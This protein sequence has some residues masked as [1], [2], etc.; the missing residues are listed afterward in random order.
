[1][2]QFLLKV[3]VVLLAA[4]PIFANTAVASYATDKKVAATDSTEEI[5]KRLAEIEAQLAEC[6]NMLSYGMVM[7]DYNY[8]K[9]YDEV[10]YVDDEKLFWHNSEGFDNL[11]AEMDLIAVMLNDS[12]D[13]CQYISE[14]IVRVRDSADYTYEE[15][16]EFCSDIEVMVMEVMT[17][18][19]EINTRLD[20]FEAVYVDFICYGVNQPDPATQYALYHVPTGKYLTYS[21]GVIELSDTQSPFNMEFVMCDVNSSYVTLI[22]ADG[23]V[24]QSGG[25]TQ[26][27]FTPADTVN[28]MSDIVVPSGSI[29]DMWQ[30][31]VYDSTPT[32]ISSATTGVPDSRRND[33]YYNLNGQ[34]ISKPSKGIYIHRGKKILLK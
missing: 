3:M 11:R 30:I 16:L 21:A 6:V 5:D 19:V 13:Y 29:G 33:A 26:W 31:T 20:H 22:N 14:E 4:S 34:R 7:C 32:G 18:S 17:M 9:L 25:K 27:S 1:M 10:Q 23:E 8:A 12:Y 15:L 2:K 24:M 28:Y